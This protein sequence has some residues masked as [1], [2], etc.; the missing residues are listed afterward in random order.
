MDMG[1]TGALSWQPLVDAGL[2]QVIGFEPVEEE[3]RHLCAKALGHQRFLPYAIGDGSRRRL[4]LTR[5]PPCTSVFEPNRPFL[6]LFQD[7]P[8][9]FEITGAAE[10]QTRRLDDI[11]ELRETGCDYLKLDIQGAERMALENAARILSGTLM[12]E[13]EINLTPLY[14]GSPRAGEL[15]ALLRKAGFML[16]RYIG[17][18]G[19]TLKPLPARPG[20]GEFMSQTL[21][22]E[23]VY[24]R[25]YTRPESLDAGQ[26]IRF[27][28]L[29]HAL[30][31]AADLALLALSRADGLLGTGY[32]TEYARRVAAAREA[33]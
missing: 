7:L 26:W 25:D 20:S 29:A 17:S 9:L 16:W 2:A 8:S 13:I 4:H 28:M 18:G 12:V 22:C 11:E 30:H 31:G 1:N 5:F 32:A 24:A 21:W 6:D 27:A 19:R 14:A 33:S 10:V 15:D 23:T 3:C